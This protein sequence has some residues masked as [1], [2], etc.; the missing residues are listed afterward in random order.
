MHRYPGP[1]HTDPLHAVH[2]IPESARAGATYTKGTTMLYEFALPN[3]DDMGL[4][5]FVI[6]RI[7]SPRVCPVPGPPLQEALS[8]LVAGMHVVIVHRDVNGD[9]RLFGDELLAS[10]LVGL[11]LDAQRW[12]AFEFAG[13][14]D[15]DLPS[16]GLAA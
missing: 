15:D 6:A 8:A 10:R 5:P 12:V 2:L 13:D 1:P 7:A 4:P 3:I 11:D 9:T 14:R 16:L